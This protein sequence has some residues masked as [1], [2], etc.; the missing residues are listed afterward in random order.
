MRAKF[1]QGGEIALEVWGTVDLEVPVAL[2][3]DD[4]LPLARE[5]VPSHVYGGVG[6]LAGS[7][8]ELGDRLDVR[9]RFGKPLHE[10]LGPGQELILGAVL[11]DASSRVRA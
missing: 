7:E 6:M 10:P 11:L 2:L 4:G 3:V 9:R 8:Y 1:G 5:L